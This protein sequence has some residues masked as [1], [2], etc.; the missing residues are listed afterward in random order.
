MGILYRNLAKYLNNT[1]LKVNYVE[2][3]KGVLNSMYHWPTKDDKNDWCKL[4]GYVPDFFQD[5]QDILS[6]VDDVVS[7]DRSENQDQ[8]KKVLV[9]SLKDDNKAPVAPKQKIEDLS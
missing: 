4:F 9:S 1:N 8:I 3:W 5:T 2:E 6:T 7:K